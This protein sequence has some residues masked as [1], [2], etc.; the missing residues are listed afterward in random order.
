[1]HT[2]ASFAVVC[3]LSLNGLWWFTMKNTPSIRQM[4]D[5]WGAI[6]SLQ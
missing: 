1:M 3:G 4:S 5:L 2:A 6:Q